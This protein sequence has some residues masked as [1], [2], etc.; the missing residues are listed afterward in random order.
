VKLAIVVTILCGCV[1]TRAVLA[2]DVTRLGQIPD[3]NQLN[4]QIIRGQPAAKSDWPGTA[5][6]EVQYGP[7]IMQCTATV[8]GPQ[9]L[10][11]AAHCVKSTGD[12]VLNYDNIWYDLACTIHPDF[13]GSNCFGSDATSER[14][15][16]QCTADIALCKSDEPIKGA[17]PELLKLS[18]PGF[19]RGAA[20]VVLGYGC[21]QEGGKTSETLQVGEAVV[22]FVP[23]NVPDMNHPLADFAHLSPKNGSVVCDGDSGGAAYDSG[24]RNQRVILG[25]AARVNLSQGSYF[26]DITDA[27]ISEWIANYLQANGVTL[28]KPADGN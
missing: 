18:T 21:L 16:L 6:Y 14:E 5:V 20:A 22:A 27:R 10:L 7:K 26:V 28:A 4:P 17:Q 1:L 8:V 9:L 19:R 13:Q 15:L 2:G 3:D 23:S 12:K 25:V 11:T 24:K